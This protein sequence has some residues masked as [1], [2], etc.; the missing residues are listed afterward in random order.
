M[1]L[2]PAGYALPEAKAAAEDNAAAPP[3]TRAARKAARKARLAGKEPKKPEPEMQVSHLIIVI[4]IYRIAIC[5][6]CLGLL[7]TLLLCMAS[8]SV[9]YDA[10]HARVSSMGGD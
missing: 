10:S 1:L 6:G 2:N 3:S 4:A 8:P 5:R 7:C 9:H